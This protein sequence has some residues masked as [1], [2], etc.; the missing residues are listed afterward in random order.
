[1]QIIGQLAA[2]T[3]G[4]I[5]PFSVVSRCD[6]ARHSHYSD[7][8]IVTCLVH[9]AV[10]IE[11]TRFTK[12]DTRELLLQLLADRNGHQ[13][14]WTPQAL[15]ASIMDCTGGHRGLTGV[16]LASVDD[17]DE[18]IKS[19]TTISEASWANMEAHLPFL[20]GSGGIAT[21]HALVTD[22]VAVQD[23]DGIQGILETMLHNAGLVGQIVWIQCR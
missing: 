16:C 22:L 14:D 15:A 13:M 20:L 10:Y 9:Q 8:D 12:D 2:T 17:V 11:P 7:P 5:S 4:S 6:F 18:M 23:D 19:G 1:M 3:A 21:Y